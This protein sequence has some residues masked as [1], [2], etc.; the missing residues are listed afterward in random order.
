MIIPNRDFDPKIK[1]LDNQ[2]DKL[3]IE[4]YIIL[5][6]FETQLRQRPLLMLQREFPLHHTTTTLLNLECIEYL[7]KAAIK[8]CFDWTM[9]DSMYKTLLHTL[10]CKLKPNSIIWL[11]ANVDIAES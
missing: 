8:D 7:K 11:L 10:M 3:G 5:Y 9:V 4:D 6:R 1:P 2:E